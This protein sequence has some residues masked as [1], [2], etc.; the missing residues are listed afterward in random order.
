MVEISSK[1]SFRGSGGTPLK[2]KSISSPVVF[3]EMS[4]RE[5][6]SDLASKVDV[7]SESQ[8]E[9]RSA[10]EMSAGG[11]GDILKVQVD[12]AKLTHH[13]DSMKTNIR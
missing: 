2:T 12:F 1:D 9:E 6:K 4:G 7:V 13:L 3:Q 8:E 11:I 10:S 5:I